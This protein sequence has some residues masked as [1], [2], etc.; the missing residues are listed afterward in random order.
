MEVSHHQQKIYV[1]MHSYSFFFSVT[2]LISL[3]TENQ[4]KPGYKF[5][6]IRAKRL[7]AF[8]DE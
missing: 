3:W 5:T 2:C 1:L 8:K 6:I 7:D 4:S